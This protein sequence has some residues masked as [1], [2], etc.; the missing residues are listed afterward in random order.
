MICD[1]G[2]GLMEG[3]IDTMS[4]AGFKDLILVRKRRNAKWSDARIRAISLPLR[5]VS[6]E[7]PLGIKSI[8]SVA[9]YLIIATFI[10]TLVV[11]KHRLDTVIGVFAFPQGLAAL[12]IA[13]ITHRKAVIFTDGGD[14][15]VIFRNTLVRAI[16]PAYLRRA[17]VVTALNESK[18]NSLISLGIR[19][20]VCPTIGVNVSDFEHVPLDEKERHHILYV[21][22]LSRE[23]GPDILVR[24]LS[25]L[26]QRGVRFEALLLGD[27]PL[28]NEIDGTILGTG[29]GN[30]VQ[31]KG[32]VPHSE[33]HRF[34]KRKAIFVLPSAREGVSVSLLEAMSS[35]CL[36]V[37]SDIPDNREVIQNMKNGITFRAGDEEDL[38]N[39][40]EWA[41]EHLA[42]LQSLA[43]N[44]R[45]IAE[46]RYSIEAV[47]S[48]LRS[49]L[50]RLEAH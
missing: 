18:R 33:V 8:I 29:I 16:G 32:Y 49:I 19:A 24:A 43:A 40:L 9:A 17:A 7:E 48:G 15:D 26:N 20:E 12:L 22:R 42:S 30:V 6:D 41:M 11:A 39:K 3:L 34:Y 25:R 28:R 31:T 4:Y 10:G 1:Y 13:T 44:A 5:V 37:V 45:H 46:R 50:S 38:A 36:C 2:H 27:G 14:I 23:K 47:G 21:G 35:G